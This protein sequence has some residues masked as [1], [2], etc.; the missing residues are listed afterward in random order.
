MALLT[1]GPISTPGDLQAFEYAILSVA[2]TECIDLAGKIILAQNDIANH[3]TLF[4][5]RRL[6][7]RD[8]QWTDRRSRGVHDVVVTGPL[9]QWH[10]HKTLALVYRDAYNNQLNDRYQ[11]KWAEY[12]QLTKESQCSYLNIG[13][14]LAADPIPKADVPTLSAVAGCGAAATF[15]VEITWVNQTGEQGAP[16][17]VS[18]LNTSDGQQLVVM[19]ANPPANAKGWNAY[20]GSSPEALALQN[21]GPIAIG[22]NW[23]MTMAL[24]AGPAPASGQQPTWFVVDQQVT[25]RG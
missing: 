20:V 2:S 18:Q 13:V 15:Y 14:A 17:D 6:P 10:A 8:F 21:N 12:E 3:L 23:T 9:R 22:A 1:D 25:Q 4:L 5:L 16:S 11:G 7:I 24:Q 19:A